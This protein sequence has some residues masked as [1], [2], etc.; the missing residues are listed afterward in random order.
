MPLSHKTFWGELFWSN[1]LK[2]QVLNVRTPVRRIDDAFIGGL[3]ATVAV[4][5][6]SKL[7]Q[8]PGD[9]AR[10]VFR[11]DE[12]LAAPRDS[13]ARRTASGIPYLAP[14]AVLLF[15]AKGGRDKDEADFAAAAPDLG[16]EARAWL[17]DALA[18]TAPGHPWIGRLMAYT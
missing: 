1:L 5:D 2:Q 17:I 18:R 10:W 6:L 14:E 16:A 3:V 4:G 7:M 15:K 9:A 12:R 11:R 8:E 13:L